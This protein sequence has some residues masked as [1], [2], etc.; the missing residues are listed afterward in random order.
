VSGDERDWWQARL[1][2]AE[3]ERDHAWREVARLESE[4]L[5]VRAE[6]DAKEKVIRARWP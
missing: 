5:D 6:R 1:R 2:L 3:A 4:L